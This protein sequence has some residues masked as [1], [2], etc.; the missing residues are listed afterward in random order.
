[1]VKN[2]NLRKTALQ[3]CLMLSIFSLN[4]GP[5]RSADSEIFGFVRFSFPSRGET[6]RTYEVFSYAIYQVRGS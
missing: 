3:Y 5:A 4:A 6:P 2:P 1:M